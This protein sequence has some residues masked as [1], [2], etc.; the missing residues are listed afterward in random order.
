MYCKSI[1]FFSYYATLALDNPSRQKEYF[2]K[3]MKT[4]HNT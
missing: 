2:R 3:N 1:F 4:N